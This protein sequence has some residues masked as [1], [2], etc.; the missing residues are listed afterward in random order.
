MVIGAGLFRYLDMVFVGIHVDAMNTY[1]I[2][3]RKKGRP[4]LSERYH[5]WE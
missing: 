4:T 2:F 1:T 3:S 5:F